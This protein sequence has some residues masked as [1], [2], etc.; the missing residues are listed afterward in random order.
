MSPEQKW[1]ALRQLAKKRRRDRRAGYCCLADFNEGYFECCFVSP[2]TKSAHNLGANVMLLGQDWSSSNAL[3]RVLNETEPEKAIEIR[4]LGQTYKLP[5]NKRLRRFLKE[6]V[7]LEFSET[8]ATNLFPFIKKGA[9]NAKIQ[10]RDMDYCAKEYAIPQIEIV[11]PK[12]VICL[13]KS[14]YEAI[15][16]FL[17]LG[18][19]FFKQTSQPIHC[20]RHR[21]VEI[22]GLPHP[23]YWGVRNAGGEECVLEHWQAL[24]NRLIELQTH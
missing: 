10:A 1:A 15:C 11:Q 4:K 9:L 14:T 2:W 16:R 7:G 21:G 20:I 19:Q 22:Y 3:D 18:E 12:M 17:D 5:T 24:G 8:Y 6:G 13:G 23:G